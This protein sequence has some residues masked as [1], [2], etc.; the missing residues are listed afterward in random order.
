MRIHIVLDDDLIAAIDQR[1]GERTRSEYIASVL[2]AAIDNE[3]RWDEV[4]A[5]LG[6]LAGI[7]HDWDVDPA[8]SVRLQ[9]SNSRRTGEGGYRI[10]MVRHAFDDGLRLLLG[11]FPLQP[12]RLGTSPVQRAEGG[13][14]RDLSPGPPGNMGRGDGTRG[15]AENAMPQSC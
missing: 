6:V 13:V 14:R 10:G 15:G 12:R 3:Q 5:G 11:F 1:A 2:R 4:E 7:E 9:R 8:A